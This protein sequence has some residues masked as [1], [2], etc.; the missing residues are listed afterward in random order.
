MYMYII[1]KC[2]QR[3]WA[4]YMYLHCLGF[5]TILME[6]QRFDGH[7]AVDSKSSGHVWK[8]TSKSKF[9]HT[10]GYLLSKMYFQRCILWE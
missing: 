10:S 8:Y 5:A 7:S 6:R 1:P 2:R 4:S 3:H 9:S